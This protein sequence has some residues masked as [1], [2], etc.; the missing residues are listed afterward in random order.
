MGS[1]SR[2][3]VMTLILTPEGNMEKELAVKKCG[4]D[5]F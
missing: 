3:N 1:V 2:K 4:Q 5:S